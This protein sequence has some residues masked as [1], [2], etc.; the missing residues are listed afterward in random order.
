MSILEQISINP[1]LVPGLSKFF[2][3]MT[4]VWGFKVW[5]DVY[6]VRHY[7]PRIYT[8]LVVQSCVMP[9][10]TVF[11]ILYVLNVHYHSAVGYFGWACINVLFMAT[12]RMMASTLARVLKQNDLNKMQF[13]GGMA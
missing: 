3:L 5:R 8:L 12:D 2:Y 11:A 9:T 7:H 6:R 13:N 1:D 4:T 10:Y